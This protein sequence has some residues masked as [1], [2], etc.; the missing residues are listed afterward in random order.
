MVTK[1]VYVMLHSPWLKNCQISSKEEECLSPRCYKQEGRLQ[2]C[3]FV[4]GN[5]WSPVLSLTRECTNIYPLWGE[6]RVFELTIVNHFE[7]I[8]LK[9]IIFN[10]KHWASSFLKTPFSVICS[11]YVCKFSSFKWNWKSIIQVPCV[12]F[13][14]LDVKFY[15]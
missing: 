8:R 2:K 7:L 9:N 10:S 5:L 1:G 13:I 15:T 4:Q 6:Y 11:I 14:T 3:S 12:Y